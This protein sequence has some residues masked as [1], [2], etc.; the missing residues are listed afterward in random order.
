MPRRTSLALPLLAL[1]A[2]LLVGGCSP[3]APA[4]AR[5][6]HRPTVLAAAD[7]LPAPELAGPDV[8]GGTPTSLASHRG[9]VVV[10]NIWASWCGPCR[11]EAGALEEVRGRTA[12]SDVR[13]LGINTRDPDVSAARS[14]VAAHGQHFPSI[15]D[16]RGT[17]PL[18]FPAGTINPQAVPATV[19]I[20]RQGRIAAATSGPVTAPD[21]TALLDTVL[22]E[23]S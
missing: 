6:A 17:L 21:L 15:H 8:G 7:R 18:R 10:V 1:V 13:F 19:V 11:A 3:D 9:H 4:D 12:A 22:A 23:P 2:A 20:D 16:P 14:F 5:A